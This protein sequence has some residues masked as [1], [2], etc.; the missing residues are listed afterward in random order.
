MAPCTTVTFRRL[1]ELCRG[2][3][4]AP[5]G[6]L[7]S[8]G[9]PCLW[10]DSNVEQEDERGLPDTGDSRHRTCTR[11]PVAKYEIHPGRIHTLLHFLGADKERKINFLG[12]SLQNF[13]CIKSHGICKYLSNFLMIRIETYLST[14][15]IKMIKSDSSIRQ[16][17]L[18]ILPLFTSHLIFNS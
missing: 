4:N 16:T 1:I 14:I 9:T 12:F 8:E 15:T 2:A 6:L 11:I 18:L 17:T 7:S 5:A 13:L 10:E 3:L